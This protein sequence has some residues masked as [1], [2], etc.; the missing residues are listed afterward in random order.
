MTIEQAQSQPETRHSEV[1]SDA[2]LAC[3]FCG[4]FP[5][6]EIKVDEGAHGMYVFAIK[7]SCNG[8]AG[9][10]LSL[11]FKNQTPHEQCLTTLQNCVTLYSAEWNRRH[12][13]AR[14]DP[15][16]AGA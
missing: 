12:A 9:G 8:F 1:R 6:V 2:L 10:H 14:V 13:N 5:E 11:F 7:H 3:R 15:R 16:T 4:Q